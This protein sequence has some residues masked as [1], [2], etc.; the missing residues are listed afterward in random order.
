M[1]YPNQ[2]IL[3]VLFLLFISIYYFMPCNECDEYYVNSKQRQKNKKVYET[4]KELDDIEM[5][6]KQTDFI[7]VNT[8][9]SDCS[10]YIYFNNQNKRNMFNVG[11]IQP[12][13]PRQIIRNVIPTLSV[14]ENE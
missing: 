2:Y 9:S 4:E 8:P 5:V 10:N 13:S 14:Q 6:S 11:K 3:L 12:Q 1:S 7:T